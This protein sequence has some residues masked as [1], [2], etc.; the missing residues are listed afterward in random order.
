VVVGESRTFA[1]GLAWLRENGVRVVDLDS[2]ECRLL[3]E[4]FIREHPAIW[5]EDIGEL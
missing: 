1:G 4:G 2:E 5:N 3:M